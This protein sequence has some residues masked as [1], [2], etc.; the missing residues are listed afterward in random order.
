MGEDSWDALGS[1]YD[2]DHGLS[3][4]SLEEE[5]GRGVRGHPSI[6][7]DVAAVD[8]VGDGGSHHEE[9]VDT[10]IAGRGGWGMND[11]ANFPEPAGGFELLWGA[12]PV[13]TQNQRV[14]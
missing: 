4:G 10:T 8:L 1:P 12:I 14:N 2:P 13:A 7:D 5:A 3:G 9:V 11:A 6:T